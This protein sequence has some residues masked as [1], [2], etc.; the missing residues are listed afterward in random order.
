VNGNGDEHYVTSADARL[1][2][3]V[4]GTGIPLLMFNG[5]PGCDDYLAPVA[6]LI[7]DV[8]RVIRFEPRGCGR[9]DWDGQYD[10]DTLLQ[11][12]EALRQAYGVQQWIVAGHSAGVDMALAYALRYPDKTVGL[13]GIAGGKVVDDRQWSATYHARL[14]TVGED[15]GGQE[16]KA[17]PDVNR[18][19][20][21][22]WRAFCRRSTLLCELATL[23][24]PCV[25]INAAEDIRPNWPA[26][27]LAEL[28][29]HGQYIEI[30]GAAHYVWLTHAPQLQLAMR[31]AL[32]DIG[33]I[34]PD[35]D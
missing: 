9:S 24:L 34:E 26:Q 4:S 35:Q 33:T 13:I 7:D 28:I 16:F 32:V 1:W 25:F 23:P 14:E 30:A 15:H 8:A 31:Q 12:V 19:G 20:N 27:Q 21:A 22:S 10:L 18:Q 2:S 6:A 11:D 17:D 3:T 29:P 5:G